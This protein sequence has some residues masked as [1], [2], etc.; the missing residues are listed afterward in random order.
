MSV[1]SKAKY[2]HDL[3][4]EYRRRDL[5]GDEELPLDRDAIVN[6]NREHTVQTSSALQDLLTQLAHLELKTSEAEN[7]IRYGAG[8]RLKMVQHAFSKITSIARPDR[9]MRLS[10]E[11]G[12]NLTGNLN[13]LYLNITGILD[14]LAW[15]LL[16]EKTE[17]APSLEPHRVGLFK[18]T[19]RNNSVFLELYSVIDEHVEWDKTFRQKR[20]P[21][22]HSVPLTVPPFFATPDERKEYE[23]H[24][25]A[26]QAEAAHLRLDKPSEVP[27]NLNDIGTF[28]P[29]FLR[30]Y[31]D[32]LIP[33]YPTVA[34]DLQRVKELSYGVIDFLTETRAL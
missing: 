29:V 11:E 23:N 4:K 20:D 28:I 19:I 25:S 13:I 31:D 3:A 1:T 6:L 16:Y 9:S 21:A 27:A 8:R 2:F 7:F 30:S 5:A 22:N 33:I 12:T 24:R 14:N 32:G 17:D 15:A 34:D 10:E 26:M 18:E